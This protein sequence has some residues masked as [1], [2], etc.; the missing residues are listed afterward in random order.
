MNWFLQGTRRADPAAPQPEAMDAPLPSGAEQVRRSFQLERIKTD[1]AIRQSLIGRDV[2]NEMVDALGGREALK[3][4]GIRDYRPK[5]KPGLFSDTFDYSPV[6]ALTDRVRQLREFDPARFATMPASVEEFEAE[7]RRRDKA[8]EDEARA[9][10]GRGDSTLAQLAGGIAGAMTDP[11]NIGLAFLSGGTGTG[12]RG[13][14][15]FAAR[16]AALGA[17]GEVSSIAGQ[18]ARA[19]RLG[20]P[21][22]EIAEQLAMGAAGGFVLGAAV[23][24]VANYLEYRSTRKQAEAAARPEGVAGIDHEGA[25]DAA[26]EALKAG[27]PVPPPP[28]APGAGAGAAPEGSTGGFRAVAEAGAGYTVVIAPDGTALRREGTRAWRNNNPGN[29][30]YGPFAKAQGAIG[31]DGRFAVFPTYEAG[32]AAKASLLWESKGYR[33]LTIRQAINRYAPP[34]ENDTGAYVQAVARAAGAEADTPMASLTPAQ[35]TAMLDA[36]ERVEG[37]KPGRENGVPVPDRPRAPDSFA[38]PGAAAP[39]APSALRRGQTAGDEVVSPSGM[40]AQVQYR[41]MDL[42]DLRQAEGILQNRD[43][44]TRAASDE[45]VAAIASRLDPA[46]L[47]PGPFADRGAPVIGPDAVIESGNGRVRALARVADQDPA[48]FQ[49]YVEQIRAAGFDVPEGMARPVLVAQRTED[50]DMPTRRDW[51]TG[52]NSA[53]A[54]RLSRAEQALTDADYLTPAAFDAFTPGA[55]LAD[56]GEFLRRV[57]G[58]MPL[59]E[60]GMMY[61]ADGSPSAEGLMRIRDALFGR[62]FPAQDIVRLAVESENRSV[63]ALVEM[64]ADIAPDWAML[65]NLTD[66]GYVRPEFDIT[67]ELMTVVRAIADARIADR[68]GQSVVAAV[69]DALGQGDMFA[70]NPRDPALIEALVDV[71]YRGDRARGAE[72]SGAILRRYAAE[73]MARGR[74]DDL[75]LLADT[76]PTPAEAL[77]AAVRGHERKDPMPAA[78]ARPTPEPVATPDVQAIDP[79]PFT[80]G[81]ASPLVQAA[82]DAL[83]AD[84]RG[85]FDAPEAAPVAQVENAA[86]DLAPELVAQVRAAGGRADLE[87]ALM[88]YAEA[89]AARAKIKSG[90]VAKMRGAAIRQQETY[91]RIA[92]FRPA[93]EGLSRAMRE[94]DVPL[95]QSLDPLGEITSAIDDAVRTANFSGATQTRKDPKAVARDAMATPAFQGYAARVWESAP[96]P[97]PLRQVA[98][99]AA[100]DDQRARIA[101]A[102]AALPQPSPAARAL[103]DTP[104]PLGDGPDAPVVTAREMLAEIDQDADL[105]ATLEACKIGGRG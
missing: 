52:N 36:M 13:A 57:I 29:I 75:D 69:R 77:A 24:G 62:A 92:A 21:E 31:T 19:E 10:L 81:T 70:A 89:A 85:L 6:A 48:T 27:R 55:R 38:P 32:R 104:M 43:R 99:P 87:A 40:R 67:D 96:V 7:L 105:I 86:S 1:P 18:Q 60:R 76:P 37:F 39:F 78:P 30:E 88:E 9:V 100:P 90:D 64:L 63:R 68:D 23:G 11:A 98:P 49:A 58:Q 28:V 65:R 71:F 4:A 25:L 91:Q 20:T 3:D 34:F 16:E 74:P 35:R 93:P 26:E 51:V 53:A 44:S 5:V 17:A 41:V 47:M 102:R 12:A 61:N 56:Q 42:S 14:L 2:F 84:L 72:A 45:Q 22:P 15:T 33:G 73:A 83:E 82:D 97:A 101:E 80:D 50:W 79:A 46:M 59:G 95:F 103:D 66:A 8:E 94:A 54:A